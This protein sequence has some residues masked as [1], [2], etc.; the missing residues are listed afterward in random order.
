MAHAG[1][2]PQGGPPRGAGAGAPGTAGDRGSARDRSAGVADVS[3]S[4]AAPPAAPRVVAARGSGAQVRRRDPV[5]SHLVF[6]LSQCIFFARC[7]AIVRLW[8]RT[9]RNDPVIGLRPDLSVLVC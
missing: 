2:G 5:L 4:G 3:N 8:A 6:E 7:L 1:R 9:L